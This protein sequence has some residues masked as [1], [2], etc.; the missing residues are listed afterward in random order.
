VAIV[1]VHRHAAE[2]LYAM[3]AISATART[4]GFVT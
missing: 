1:D 2:K 4:P 3:L